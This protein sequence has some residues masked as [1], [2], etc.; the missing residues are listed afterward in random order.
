MNTF[1]IKISPS[2]L[3]GFEGRLDRKKEKEIINRM[4]HKKV[5]VSNSL[6][7]TLP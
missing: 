4:I 3:L 1:K 6:K 7:K 2:L 5:K